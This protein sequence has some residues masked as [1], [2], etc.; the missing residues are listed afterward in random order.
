MDDSWGIGGL[1]V[2]GASERVNHE[3]QSDKQ[4]Q[5][6]AKLEKSEIFPFDLKWSKSH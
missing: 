1:R 3:K 4:S 2:G 6:S 5:K